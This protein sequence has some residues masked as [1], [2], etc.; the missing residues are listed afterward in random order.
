MQLVLAVATV[1]GCAVVWAAGSLSANGAAAGRG[2]AGIVV[3]LAAALLL[4][5]GYGYLQWISTTQAPG[6][7]GDPVQYGFADTPDIPGAWQFLDISQRWTATSRWQCRARGRL[8][9]LGSRWKS[10]AT[11]SIRFAPQSMRGLTSSLE[12]TVG[13]H[14]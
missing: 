6:F 14:M 10:S 1:I 7:A 13:I 12:R 4:G 2:R 8:L 11:P 5:A 9:L 3:A